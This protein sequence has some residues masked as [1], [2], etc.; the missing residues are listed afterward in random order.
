[1]LDVDYRQERDS[2]AWSLDGAKTCLEIE[3]SL[4]FLAWILATYSTRVGFGLVLGCL[5]FGG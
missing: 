2:Q 1:M 4:R 5:E 3:G